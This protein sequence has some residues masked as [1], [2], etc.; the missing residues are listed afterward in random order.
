MCSL[1]EKSCIVLTHGGSLDGIHTN[2]SLFVSIRPEVLKKKRLYYYISA[3]N[4][5]CMQM[6][7]AGNP[8]QCLQCI[9]HVTQKKMCFHYQNKRL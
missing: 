9:D 4:E 3:H 1:A 2:D 8:Q 7:I 6:A 5:Q